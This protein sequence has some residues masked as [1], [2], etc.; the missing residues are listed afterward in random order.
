MFQSTKQI[1]FKVTRGCNLRCSYCY[2]FNK[3]EYIGEFMPF[4][5]YTKIL[6]RVFDESRYGNML[7]KGEE[8]E[9]DAINIVFHGGEPTSIGKK[10]FMKYA[11]IAHQIARRYNKVLNLSIQTNGTQID[12]EWIAMFRKYKVTPGISLDG[13]LEQ[14][15]NERNAGG[16]LIE[17]CLRLK[18]SN[19]LDSILMVLHKSNY[20]SIERNLEIL[21]S[22]GIKSAKINRGVD[23]T[24]AGE[25]DYELNAKDLFESY[26]KVFNFMMTH[27]DFAEDNVLQWMEKYLSQTGKGIE[28]KDYGMHCYTR[29]CGAGNA[30]IEIEP[31]GNIQFCGRNSK[32]S[33]LTS[34]GNALTR[35]VAEINHVG[36][37]FLFHRDKL[38]S[39][40]ERGCNLC[41]AQSICDG[42]CI[43]FSQQKYGKSIIDPT[44]CALHKMMHTFLSTQDKEIKE[45]MKERNV[46][47]ESNNYFYL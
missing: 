6:E 8:R 19:M 9:Q 1:I 39:I 23:V 10:N 35:D 26:K 16:K 29:Y 40:V 7:E 4:D 47:S 2:L 32:F 30:L 41:H 21:N 14:S 27:P 17:T 13:F 18:G 46:P 12:D 11:K 34:S 31:D 33:E 38:D 5:L 22:I 28:G 44:T 3:D 45:Y 43:S 24:T 42:G 15:D 37:S 36:R 20:K 25:S